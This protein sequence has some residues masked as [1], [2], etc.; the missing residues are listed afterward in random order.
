MAYNINQGL[1]P[2]INTVAYRTKH[3]EIYRECCLRMIGQLIFENTMDV[4]EN[5]IET[6]YLYV[7]R[8]AFLPDHVHQSNLAAKH[9]ITTDNDFFPKTLK[10]SINCIANL[11]V[12]EQSAYIQ[13]NNL[14]I[15]RLLK[16]EFD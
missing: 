2:G 5:L 11:L 16:K 1:N 13:Q 10:S 4:P 15:Y 9:T 12:Q 8:I 6:I 14:A 7:S 3:D